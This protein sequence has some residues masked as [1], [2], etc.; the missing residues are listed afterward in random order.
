MGDNRSP[1]T[2]L[3]SLPS[4]GGLI[5]LQARLTNPVT[6][7]GPT[8]ATLCGVIASNSSARLDGRGWIR[9]AL[10]LLLVDGGWGTLWAAVA[11]T[12]W[13]PA[14]RQWRHWRS[15]DPIYPLP[16]TLPDTLADR[17]TIWIGQLL[18]WWRNSLWPTCGPSISAIAATLPVTALLST[19][20][21]TELLL[22]TGGAIAIMQLTLA[23]E[24]GKGSCPAGWD[25][26]V[27]L[28]LP[29]LAGHMAFGTLTL[30]STAASLAFAVAWAGS[31]WQASSCTR[32]ALGIGFQLSVVLLLIV[33]YQPLSAALLVILITPQ[34]ALLPW[35]RRGQSS[36][37]FARHSRPWVMAA[38]LLASWV[39]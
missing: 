7:V 29:W 6:W 35:L 27:S 34:M 11:G 28:A 25:A 2:A 39:L 20:L 38:M 15:S 1:T 5:H 3:P 14:V 32:R 10:L 9:L 4:A 18:S 26:I 21:G 8:W 22:L 31:T 19:M 17:L 36:A 24:G 33:L 16:Y 30:A 12:D 37:W 23:W 13:S